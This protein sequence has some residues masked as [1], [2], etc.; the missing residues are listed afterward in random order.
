M[1]SASAHKPY[2]ASLQKFDFQSNRSMEF[3]SLP[4]KDGHSIP[5]VSIAELPG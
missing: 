1:H 4:L 5:L 3:V 2:A